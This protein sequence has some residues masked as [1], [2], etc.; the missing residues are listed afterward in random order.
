MIPFKARGNK[1][2]PCGNKK[3]YS[4]PPSQ[5]VKALET[6]LIRIAIFAQNRPPYP[7]S[8]ANEIFLLLP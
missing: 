5:D 7:L 3:N 2:L 6:L 1:I 8:I 4:M